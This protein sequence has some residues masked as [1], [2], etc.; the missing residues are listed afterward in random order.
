M[1]RKLDPDYPAFKKS[2]TLIAPRASDGISV[3]DKE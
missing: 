1:V 3:A 2:A